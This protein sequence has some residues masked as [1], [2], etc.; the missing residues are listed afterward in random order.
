MTSP[1]NMMNKAGI[2]IVTAL[3][4]P[5]L[6]PRATIVTVI[7]MN[8]ACQPISTSGWWR[9]PSN[10]APTASA[11]RPANVP[12]AV[13]NIYAIDQP[14]ITLKKL[15][16]RNIVTMPSQPT[17]CQAGLARTAVATILNEFG[18]LLRPYLPIIISPI[19]TGVAMTMIANR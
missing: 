10:S 6:M 1:I 15:N 11:A 16:T 9:K 19:I 7:A 3:S 14:A 17:Y 12:A 2:I 4:M 18:A 13:L 8:S 5:A